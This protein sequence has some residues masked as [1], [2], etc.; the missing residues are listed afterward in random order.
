MANA[1][2]SQGMRDD[3]LNGTAIETAFDSG[4]LEIRDG[5]QP[6]SAN[7]APVGTILASVDLPVSAFA[8]IANGVLSKDTGAWEELSAP[9]A[10]TATWFR[11]RTSGDLGT[12][13]TTDVRV[14]GDV[15][16]VA[17][18]TGDLQLATTVI[19]ITDKVVVDSF[20]ITIPEAGA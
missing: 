12:T 2:F 14:D 8:A 4:V 20:T 6:T 9:A 11:L 18:G 7:D 3:M 16:T 13:N 1:K 17:A 15:S 19:A 5:T 10:G